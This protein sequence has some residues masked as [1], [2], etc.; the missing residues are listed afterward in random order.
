VFIAALDS[1]RGCH[2][3]APGSGL[4]AYQ[5]RCPLGVLL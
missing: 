3:G 4:G 1:R 5:E 2:P